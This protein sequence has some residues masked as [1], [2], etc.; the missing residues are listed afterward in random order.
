MSE[1]KSALATNKWL[2]KSGILFVAVGVIFAVPVHSRAGQLEDGR[3]AY[4]AANYAEAMRLLRPLAEQRNAEAQIYLGLLYAKGQG[5]PQDYA[6]AARWYRKA[7]EQG[8]ALGQYNLGFMY[9]RGQGVPQD[10]AEAARWYRKAA[11][12]GQANAQYNLGLMYEKGQGVAPDSAEAVKRA[13]KAKEQGHVSIEKSNLGL[14][15]TSDLARAGRKL[16]QEDAEKLEE[17]LKSDP[18]DLSARARLL[19]YYFAGSLPRAGRV[20]TLAARRRH[21]LWIIQH[22]PDAEI[23]GL[24]EA[25]LDPTGHPLADQEGYALA[26]ELW[27]QQVETYR[28]N[29]SVLG[30]A[31]KFFQLPDKEIA[32]RILM[33]ARAFDPGG[34]WTGRLAYLYALGIL[35]VNG[36]THTGIPTSVDESPAASEFAKKAR[37][38]LAKPENA[39]MVFMTSS[40]ISQ[41]GT[42][43]RGMGL[44]Q[45]DPATLIQDLF[46]QAAAGEGLKPTTTQCEPPAASPDTPSLS[47]GETVLGAT[48]VDLKQWEWRAGLKLVYQ[49]SSKETTSGGPKLPD[50]KRLQSKSQSRTIEVLT[51]TS[52]YVEIRVQESGGGFPAAVFRLSKDWSLLDTRIEDPAFISLEPLVKGIAKDMFNQ[53]GGGPAWVS[54]FDGRWKVGESRMIETHSTSPPKNMERVTLR[55]VV[56]IGGRRAAEFD[57]QGCGEVNV[58]GVKAQFTFTGKRFI[59]LAA[60]VTVTMKVMEDAEFVLQGERVRMHIESDETLDFAQ[61]RGLL[62]PRSE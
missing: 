45:E 22:H 8:D 26:K 7:A 1:R 28:G 47:G 40:V 56:T 31:A 55:R 18:S 23:A 49:V 27:L 33:R 51:V 35:Q 36:L 41:Y 59:D 2:L 46:K 11:E 42:M 10:Y 48:E 6:E 61:S 3:I 53:K 19:G 39:G 29:I 43:L 52:S 32:E 4:A 62:V 16:S 24:P 54:R 25:T 37:E 21:I 20:P 9:Q 30:H 12:Q 17:K 38:G 44:I 60:G 58:F 5:V 13:R 14:Q 50:D 34:P 57:S 15:Q